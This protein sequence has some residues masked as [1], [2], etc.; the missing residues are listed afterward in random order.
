MLAKEHKARLSARIRQSLVRDQDY[1]VGLVD[2]T[3]DPGR[4]RTVLSADVTVEER[5]GE[6]VVVLPD[7]AVFPAVDVFAHVLT[8]LS[9]DLFRVLP[10]A[11]HTPRVA[12]DRLVIARETWRPPAGDLTFARA[13]TEAAR[14][15]LARRWR[16]AMDLPRFTFV[17]SPA[18]PRPFY[19]DFDSPVY[20]EILSKAARRLARQDPTERL[21]ITEMLPTPEQTWLTDDTGEAYTAELR[22]V[23]VEDAPPPH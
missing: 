5:A 17:V 8:T 12:V 10:E 4:P 1:Y 18:E 13:K 7:G 21:T 2:H 9:M 23:A 16:A 3:V 14:F 6:L 15:A 20:V 22:F 19:V 11:E